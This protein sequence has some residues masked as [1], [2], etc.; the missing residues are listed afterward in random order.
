VKF[1]DIRIPDMIWII[2]VILRID[3]MFHMLLMFEP[4][5]FQ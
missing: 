5:L 1:R 4:G 2:R 3:P